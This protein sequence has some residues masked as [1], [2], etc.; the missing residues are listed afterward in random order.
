M[1]LLHFLF[2]W[3][4]MTSVFAGCDQNLVMEEMTDV[5]ETETPMEHPLKSIMRI[6]R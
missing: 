2:M 5:P 4:A 6:Y 3:V 1:K